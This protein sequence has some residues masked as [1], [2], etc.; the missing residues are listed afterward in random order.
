M[1]QTAATNLGN[2]PAA[3]HRPAVNRCDKRL[4]GAWE[5]G[6][7]ITA[8]A[9]AGPRLH[10]GG[11]IVATLF[12]ITT[13]TKGTPGTGDNRHPRRLVRVIAQN[14]VGKFLP[15]L[16]INRIQRLGTIQG[17][18]HDLILLLV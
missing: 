2:G 13:G 11:I 15:Q 16:T 9:I 8:Q 17:Y 10:P 1:P 18:R 3:G 5:Q 7:G 14:G 4:P 6:E 12:E